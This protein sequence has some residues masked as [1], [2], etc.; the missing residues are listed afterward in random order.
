MQFL[1]G[2]QLQTLIPLQHFREQWHLPDDFGV[3]LFEPKE[4]TGLG[5]MEGAG[6]DLSLVR[7]RIVQAVPMPLAP[8]GLRIAVEGLTRYFEQEL[9]AANTQVGLREVEVDFAVAG[10]GDVLQA[11]A[12]RLIQ[13]AQLYRQDPAQI[14]AKFDFAELYQTWLDGSARVSTKIHS[15]RQGETEFQ[16]RVLNNIYGRIGLEVQAG[17]E[18]Y[19][20]LD[21]ALACPAASYMRGLCQEVAQKICQ[22]LVESL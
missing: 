8:A 2:E 5:S 3:A 21:T 6:R 20:V 10:F 9:Q 4:W 15:Y 16:V 18:R 7:Q 1:I 14:A 13:L 12:Y 11:I 17:E 22:A 19:Y